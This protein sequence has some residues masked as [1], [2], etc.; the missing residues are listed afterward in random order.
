MS[1]VMTDEVDYAEMVVTLI[2]MT[3]ALNHQLEID[4]YKVSKA[5]IDQ[6]LTEARKGMFTEEDMRECAWESPEQCT[7]E[8]FI[9][10]FKQYLTERKG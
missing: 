8:E 3:T 7:A 9:L 2:K 4:L 1:N 5:V 6:A 10:W